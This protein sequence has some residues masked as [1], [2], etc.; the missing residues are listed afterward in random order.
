MYHHETSTNNQHAEPLQYPTNRHPTSP[1]VKKMGN[2]R[3]YHLNVHLLNRWIGRGI[4]E[5][6]IRNEELTQALNCSCISEW[7]RAK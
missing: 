4:Q 2:N 3:G 6:Y 1:T 5:K 7:I